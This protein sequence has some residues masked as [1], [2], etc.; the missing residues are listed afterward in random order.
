MFLIKKKWVE[1]EEELTNQSINK[2]IRTKGQREEDEKIVFYGL[3]KNK[4]RKPGFEISEDFLAELR[5]MDQSSLAK[6][7]L[8][9]S[10]IK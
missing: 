8:S 3:Q 6:E 7:L 4:P 5:K 1:D 10:S 9:I 2:S